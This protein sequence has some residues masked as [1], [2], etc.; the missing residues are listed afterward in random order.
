MNKERSLAIHE[1]ICKIELQTLHADRDGLDKTAQIVHLEA[2]QVAVGQLQ[3]LVS[4]EIVELRGYPPPPR[5][6]GQREGQSAR[7][8]RLL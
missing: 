1:R 3:A 7:Q 4:A 8:E 5:P 2:A 6:P